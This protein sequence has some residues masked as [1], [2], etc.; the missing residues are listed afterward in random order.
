MTTI[1][2]A[3]NSPEAVEE[4]LGIKSKAHEVEAYLRDQMRDKGIGNYS[5]AAVI[6]NGFEKIHYYPVDSQLQDG[7]LSNAVH[8]SIGETGKR[9]LKGIVQTRDLKNISSYKTG[10]FVP[11]EHFDAPETYVAVINLVSLLQ[12]DGVPEDAI[13]FP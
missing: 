3:L 2:D 11:G 12:G 8:W 1:D 10:Y 13:K 9:K 4:R 7:V 6:V 5:L